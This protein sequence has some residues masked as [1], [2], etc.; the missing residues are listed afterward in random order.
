M[1]NILELTVARAGRPSERISFPVRRMFNAGWVGR[2]KASLQHHIDELAK[3]GVPPPRHVPTLFALG[4]HM[5]T[6]AEAIQV[7]GH[8]TSGE[9]EYVLLWHRGEILVGVGSDHT[10][11][12]LETHSI[13]KAKNICLNVL[14]PVVW[15]YAEVEDHF[16]SLVLESGV[17]TG[18]SRR[19]YQRDVCGAILDPAYWIDLLQER[20][21]ALEEGLVL[22]SGT[23]GT[24]SGLVVGEAYD[25]SLQDPVMGRDIRHRYACPPLTG[26]LEDD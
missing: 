1:D 20:L 19:L 8:E 15:P 24:V 16:D 7:H 6:T 4:N 9:V 22:Y 17:I 12:K 10:D 5:L 13:P 14:A 26:A 11:R 21:G 18:D 2:D 23:I 25:L 3:L